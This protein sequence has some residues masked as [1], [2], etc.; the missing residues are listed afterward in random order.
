MFLDSIILCVCL[1][2]PKSKVGKIVFVVVMVMALVAV[3]VVIFSKILLLLGYWFGE[4][5]NH[6]VCL[7]GKNWIQGNNGVKQVARLGEII[8]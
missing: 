1:T 3:A 8:T 2:N 7:V 4:S 5:V 6:K